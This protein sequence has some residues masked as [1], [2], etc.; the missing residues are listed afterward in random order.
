MADPTN[1]PVCEIIPQIVT[2]Q[3]PQSRLPAIPIATDLNSALLALNAMRQWMMM[4]MQTNPGHGTGGGGRGGGGAGG[5]GG[6]KKADPKKPQLGRWQQK[7]ITR[8][9]VRVFNPQ[10]H[11]QYVDVSRVTRLVM[12]DSVTKEQWVWTGSA[13]S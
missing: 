8:K 7:D 3:P 10:D 11:E 12:E 1:A 6:G 4:M 9:K 2:T 5:P 13:E